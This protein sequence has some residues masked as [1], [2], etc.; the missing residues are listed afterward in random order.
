MEKENIK[1][2]TAQPQV[3][4]TS[5]N[6][7]IKKKKPW[8]I[9]TL[10]I[11]IIISV[12]SVSVLAYQNYVLKNN[13]QS[14]KERTQITPATI[15]TT[16][17]A[18]ESSFLV[19]GQITGKLAFIRDDN[20][21]SSNNGIENQITT[22]AISTEIP[23]RTGLPELYYSN[24]QISPDG[25][26]IA[27]FKNK[28]VNV[29]M[30][31][32]S[33]GPIV[34]SNIDGE[35]KKEIVNDSEEARKLLQWSDDSQQIYY[36][37]LVG[38]DSLMNDILKVKSV[39]VA[40]GQKQEYGQFILTTGCGGARPDPADHLSSS[41]NI[42]PFGGGLA[43]FGLSPKND[44]LLHS[45]SCGG[46]GLGILDLSIKK[47]RK[48]DDKAM[49]AVISSDNNRI[50]TVSDKNIV[51]FEANTN[52]IKKT[53]PT[54]ENPLVLLWGSD[55]KTIYYSTSK[56]VEE[57]N[58]EDGLYLDNS[59]DPYSYPFNV[60]QAAIWKLSLDDGKSEKIIDFDAHNVKPIFSTDKK[61][62]VVIVENSNSLYNYITQ[63][64][65]K[66]DIVKY[67][68]KVAIADVNLNNLSYSI[69][70]SN[71]QQSSYSPF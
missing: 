63:Y 19:N 7:P 64:K 66:K 43:I 58:F 5:E 28:K 56:V 55:G 34:I 21:W 62:F 65:T 22:D 49:N 53:Y 37:S 38:R 71:V 24:P 8:L 70:A 36:L 20:L 60:R 11:L 10:I 23:G 68:P 25:K 67:Y 57:L 44:Y 47:D 52:M 30:V 13:I 48:L 50:A 61:L 1:E 42:E 4:E 32:E 29:G 46:T 54:Q 51:I 31:I 69:I 39:N 27:Y 12:G 59:G 9:I 16:Q 15:P 2:E 33:I 26:K 14:E 35:N 3:T 17:I 6:S 41:E 40:T 18:T 45:I